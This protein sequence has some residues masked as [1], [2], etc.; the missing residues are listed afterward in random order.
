MNSR[1]FLQW[2]E[3]AI[4]RVGNGYFG[5][6]E[7]VY[8]YELYHF[9]RVAMH[10]YE[11]QYGQIENV[12]LHSELVKSIVPDEE[13]QV[14]EI[15]PLQS[16]RMPDFLF[17]SPGNTDHQLVAIEVKV[18]SPLSLDELVS[19]LQK[20]SELRVNYRYE[21][22]IF[23]CVNTSIDRIF[24]LIERALNRGI[25]LDPQILVICKPA[26]GEAIQKMTVGA[27]VE[28]IT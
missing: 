21:M 5:H 17:H 1:L 22:V 12:F 24:T 25:E 14:L 23:H 11:R 10:A 2:L 3:Y 4:D 18:T 8:C 19:D 15:F 9:V 27:I 6:A 28:E 13:A 20:L 16:R 7:R 26:Y